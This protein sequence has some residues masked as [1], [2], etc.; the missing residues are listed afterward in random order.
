MRTPAF[1]IKKFVKGVYTFWGIHVPS[2]LNTAKKSGYYYYHTKADAERGRAELITALTSS[3]T[4]H[5]LS[6][7]Q[8]EDAIRALNI[9][10]NHNIK[11]NLTDAITSALPLL[12]SSGAH[13]PIDELCNSFLIAKQATW[14]IAS[15]RNF[16]TIARLLTERFSGEPVSSIT[17][18]ALQTWLAER[19]K[20]PGYMQNAIRT[21]RP[22]FN[23][24]VRQGIISTSPFDKLET[25]RA[26]KKDEIDIFTPDEARRLMETAPEDCRPAYAMLLFAGVRPA[27]LTR[28]TWSNVRDGYIHITPSIAKTRQVRNIEIEPTLA[29]WLDSTGP[30]TPTEPICPKNWYRLNK[31]V[32]SEVG[33]SDRRDTAR[34]SYATYYLAKYQNADAL[35]SNL[36]HSRGSDTLFLHYRAAATP[37]TAEEYW[38]ILPHH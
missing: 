1:K 12:A 11:A 4:L 27:E 35:K 34:H 37:A 29:A 33:F 26:R 14:S 22:A 10:S 3:K 7:S 17:T 24:A 23:Y 13:M 6:N 31:A 9:L 2:Y 8:Q 18:G 16:R 36:G 5:L 21:L 28:L 20:T 25:V 32:R 19:F 30:H 15:T 38:A